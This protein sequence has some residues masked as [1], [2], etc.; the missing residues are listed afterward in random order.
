[1]IP[2]RTLL[3]L[4]SLPLLTATGCASNLGS[5]PS[6]VIELYDMA[7]PDGIIEIEINR[8]GSITAIEAEISPEEL[9]IHTREAALARTPGGKITGA[10]REVMATGS[11]WEVKVHH[12]G[13]DWE[14]VIGDDATIM[15]MEK[16][17]RRD[18]APAVVLEASDRELPSARFKSVELIQR[19]EEQEFH[20]KKLLDGATY[21][22]VLSPE[23]KLIRK[24][25]E[26]RAEIEIP[27][28]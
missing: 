7:R 14:F 3:V 25:R 12:D 16:E 4:L 15:E 11:A 22:L 17:L 28:R 2:A 5:V 19:G 20:V 9:P 1:M 24:V 18:E 27:L 6:T 8:E 13:R 26:H 21:K 10:E 23:G